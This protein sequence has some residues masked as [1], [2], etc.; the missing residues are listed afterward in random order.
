[1]GTIFLV[2]SLSK[3][4]HPRHFVASVADYK[5]LPRSFERP[6]A[7]SLPWLELVMGMLLMLGYAVRPVAVLSMALLLVFILAMI[8]NLVRGRKELDC[9]CYGRF[10]RQKIG[11]K[12]ITRNVV[13]SLLLLALAL[14]GDGLL[15]LEKH[16]PSILS[17]VWAVFLLNGFL[18]LA[19]SGLGLFMFYRL[20][21]QLAR[22]IALIEISPGP[23]EMMMHPP[24]VFLG[25][26]RDRSKIGATS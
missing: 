18:P 12:I 6:F 9:G 4:R 8:I 20:F 25:K 23:G 5:L 24:K 21:Y 7:H 26:A 11:W 1:M 2:S 22:L 17:F 3:L 13:L 15:S 14:W 19:L 10:H 16:T